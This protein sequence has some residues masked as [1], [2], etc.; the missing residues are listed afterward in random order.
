MTSMLVTA[1][2]KALQKMS[3]IQ[4]PIQFKEDQLEIK[5]LINSNN[6]VNAMTRAYKAKLD[7]IN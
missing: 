6:K 4:Y 5:T 2:L 7:F 3:Y 1:S